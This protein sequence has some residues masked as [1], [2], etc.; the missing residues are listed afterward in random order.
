MS[1]AKSL[2]PFAALLCGAVLLSS[3]IT[4]GNFPKRIAEAECDKFYEC[5]KS[6]AELAFGDPENCVEKVE[7]VYDRLV[8][9]CKDWDG[10]KASQC[11]SEVEDSSCSKI[12]I[13]TEPCE[14]LASICK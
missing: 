1:L 5:S 6:V 13:D 4:Q 10:R 11:I 12:S 3:C 8:E 7:I 14:E 9:D 2:A